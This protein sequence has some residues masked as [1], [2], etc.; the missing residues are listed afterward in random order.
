MTWTVVTDPKVEA[1]LR[2][3]WRKIPPGSDRLKRSC[4]NKA[5]NPEIG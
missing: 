2:K 3:M 5:E 1:T 4:G